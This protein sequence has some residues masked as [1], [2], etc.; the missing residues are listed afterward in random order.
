MHRGINPYLSIIFRFFCLSKKN[1]LDR[2]R[3]CV[4]MN[5]FSEHDM[6]EHHFN[7]CEDCYQKIIAEFK[8]PVEVKNKLEVL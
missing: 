5:F 6:E 8:L 2:N 1:G 7:L 3:Q 4:N